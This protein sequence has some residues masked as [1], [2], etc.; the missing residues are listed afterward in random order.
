MVELCIHE[1]EPAGC[2]WCRTVPAPPASPFSKPAGAGIGPA[3]TARYDGECA[4]CGE[5]FETGDTIRAVDHGGYIH[6]ECD[7]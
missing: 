6:D 5:S 7:E 4:G 3:F 1:M 2:A